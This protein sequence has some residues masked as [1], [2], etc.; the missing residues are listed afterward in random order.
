MFCCCAGEDVIL[1]PPPVPMPPPQ[2]MPMGYGPHPGMMP[3]P[4]GMGPNQGLKYEFLN[5]NSLKR[6]L[7]KIPR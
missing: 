5:I 3:P 4:P 6:F 7:F 1:G 2:P